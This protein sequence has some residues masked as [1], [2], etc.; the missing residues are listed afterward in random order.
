M[1]MCMS[2]CVCPC[3]RLSVFAY[4]LLLKEVRFG[5]LEHSLKLSEFGFPKFRR[6]AFKNGRFSRKEV[7][8]SWS[9]QNLSQRPDT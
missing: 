5:I 9:L 4:N 8:M 6:E 2:M 1:L 7:N 3:V